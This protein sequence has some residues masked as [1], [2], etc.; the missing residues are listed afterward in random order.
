LHADVSV[1]LAFGAGVLSFFTPCIVPV[2][3]AYLSFITGVSAEE[4]LTYDSRWKAAFPQIV[5][6]CL[7]FSAVFVVLGLAA[8]A[9]G[10]ELFRLG[11]IFRWGVGGVVLVFGIH[12][13]GI[14]EFRFLQVERRFHLKRRPAHALAAFVI[15]LAFGFGWTPCSGPILGAILAY[16]GTRETL[17]QGVLLLSCYSLGLAVPFLA[18]GLALETC[19]RWLRSARAVLRWMSVGSGVLMI[20]LGLLLITDY[21]HV[22]LWIF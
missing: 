7:G 13:V 22:I 2:L 6:F 18:M 20:I 12:L 1:F 19:L 15:G 14:I 21:L 8:T 4:V 5:L 16:A 11:P 3:P 9:A 17:G 10:A